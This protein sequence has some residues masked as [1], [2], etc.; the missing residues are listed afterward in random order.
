MDSAEL[1][2]KDGPLLY[3]LEHKKDIIK[4]FKRKAAKTLNRRH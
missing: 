4:A 2:N 3:I 1:E